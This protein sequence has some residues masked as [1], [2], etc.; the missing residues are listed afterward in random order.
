[1]SSVCVVVVRLEYLEDIRYAMVLVLQLLTMDYYTKSCCT[2]KM[3]NSYELDDKE[4]IL[5]YSLQ[6]CFVIF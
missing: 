3:F 1:M 4:C 6:N 2:I 5:L